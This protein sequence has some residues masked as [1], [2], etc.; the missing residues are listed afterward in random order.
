MSLATRGYASKLWVILPLFIV[1]ARIRERDNFFSQ[2]YFKARKTIDENKN[3]L[4]KYLYTQIVKSEATFFRCF[5]KIARNEIENDFT[6]TF[7]F[8]LE[9]CLSFASQ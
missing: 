5:A 9:K 1:G 8:I 2:F 4:R 6:F 3:I 7:K